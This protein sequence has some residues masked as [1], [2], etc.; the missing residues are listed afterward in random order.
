MKL[1]W[2]P[3][4]LV[5]VNHHFAQLLSIYTFSGTPWLPCEFPR[6]PFQV[7]KVSLRIPV[8]FLFI[9]ILLLIW[10]P[11]YSLW[12]A[13]QGIPASLEG[14]PMSSY[15]SL[16][17]TYIKGFLI[18]EFPGVPYGFRRFPNGFLY[19]G[20][21]YMNSQGFPIYQ[22]PRAPCEFLYREP[23]WIPNQEVI[24]FHLKAMLKGAC[25]NA[26]VA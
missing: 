25:K 21:L 24:E 6:V 11:T 8:V 7:P 17:R 14:F 3:C 22:L 10:R 16:S 18:Y 20:S 13:I 2:C 4:F 12:I 1:D 19:K 15:P 26:K 5:P 23:V 9:C